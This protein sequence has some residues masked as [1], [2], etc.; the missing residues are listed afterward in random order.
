MT[1]SPGLPTELVCPTTKT[2]PSATATRLASP[3]SPDWS[4]HK[5]VPVTASYALTRKG[6]IP[7]AGRRRK[8]LKP[9]QRHPR[10]KP[11]SVYHYPD[12][13][14]GPAIGAF[15]SRGRRL[16]PENRW[17]GGLDSVHG[18]Q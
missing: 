1:H 14:L 11:R 18:K 17:N 12:R 10:P 2:R 9:P 4:C 13:Q 7:N 6:A 5:R 16:G 8:P 15:L 3:R